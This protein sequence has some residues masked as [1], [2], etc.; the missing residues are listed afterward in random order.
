MIGGSGGMGMGTARAL[1]YLER[2]AAIDA[3]KVGI[4]GVTI[5]KNGIGYISIR[6]RFAVGFNRIIRQR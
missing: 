4:E 2:D 3:K 5:W 6:P 1:D